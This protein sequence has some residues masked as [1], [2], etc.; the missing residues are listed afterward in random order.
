[1]PYGW[2]IGGFGVALALIILS[3]V[4]CVSLRSSSCFAEAQGSLV[5]DPDGKSSHKFHI[6]QKPSFCCGSGRYICGKS[7]NWNQTNG[8]PSNN[9]ITIPKGYE[10]LVC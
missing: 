1:M 5:K 7:G 10:I 2:I 8:E 6:L 3:I 9:Q 4:V